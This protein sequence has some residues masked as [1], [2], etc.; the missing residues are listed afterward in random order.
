MRFRRI[1]CS[2]VGVEILTD[3]SKLRLTAT[4]K[5][6]L[7]R[8]L[9]ASFTRRYPLVS[10]C[11]KVA[12]HFLVRWLSGA[13]GHR[14]WVDT[15]GGEILVPLDDLVGR[16]V[17]FVGDLDPK[18]SQIIDIVVEPGDVALD[19]G[20]NLGLVSLRLAKRV[21]PSGRVYSFEP[22]PLM[23]AYLQATFKRNNLTNMELQQFALGETRGRLRLSVPK[24]NAG[25]ASLLDAEGMEL[26]K[27][28]ASHVVEVETLTAF[29]KKKALTRVDFVKIDVEGFESKVIKGGVDLIKEKRPRAILFEENRNITTGTKLP[30]SIRLLQ[31]CDYD[32]FAIP[33]SYFSVI[34]VELDRAISSRAICHD[35]L[36]LSK[37]LKSQLIRRRFKLS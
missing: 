28:E 18:I 27:L 15:V 29:S 37:G 21:G 30:E 5:F 14:V 36:A 3:A 7:R 11:G 4:G 9:V 31:Q 1:L 12:N 13:S 22:N 6:D 10:G 8:S 17:Y 16:A 24:G 34:L 33:R 19:I 25:A 2:G 35:F 23:V 32:V 26:D 20:A